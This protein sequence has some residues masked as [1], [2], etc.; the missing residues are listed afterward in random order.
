MQRAPGIPI[1]NTNQGIPSAYEHADDLVVGIRR[2]N[3]NEWCPHLVDVEHIGDAAGEKRTGALQLLVH[4]GKVQGE[5]LLYS[6]VLT[7]LMFAP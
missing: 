2:G 7:S 5:F 3:I 1:N 6:R 4:Y